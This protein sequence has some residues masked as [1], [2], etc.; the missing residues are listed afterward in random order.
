[1][2]ELVEE[3]GRFREGS[4]FLWPMRLLPARRREAM[5]ALYA[6]CREVDDIADGE[7][8][9][10]FALDTHHGRDC[11]VALLVAVFNVRLR[12]WRLSSA[13]GRT[14]SK[15]AGIFT[16]GRLPLPKSQG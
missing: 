16:T 9:S 7:A 2:E 12:Q 5:R 10:R 13:I 8:T 4:R 6:F 15:T 3:F 11:R 14:A 1:M